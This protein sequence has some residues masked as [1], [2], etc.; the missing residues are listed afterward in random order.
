MSAPVDR[1]GSARS[2][3]RRRRR[4]QITHEGCELFDAADGFDR[5]LAVGIRQVVSRRVAG[6]ERGRALAELGDVERIA[7][8]QRIEV[9]ADRVN[10]RQVLYVDIVL[11]TG[12]WLTCR[13][14]IA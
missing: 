14:F 1:L 2:I 11:A 13:G 12:R 4:R 8:S 5:R 7:M 10:R 9:S 3:G 6:C